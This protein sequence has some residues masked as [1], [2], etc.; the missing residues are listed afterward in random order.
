MSNEI[1]GVIVKR[2]D[3]PDEVTEFGKG[4]FE[5]VT[6]DGMTIGRA[7]Y[8]PGWRWS[9]DVGPGIGEAFCSVEHVGIVVSGDA[10]AAFADGRVAEMKPGDL[11]HLPPEPQDSQV[12]GDEPYACRHL[13]GATRLREIRRIPC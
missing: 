12:V 7:T 6:L 11:F 4:R 5:K 13:L 1:V 9:G 10:T 3:Q 2:F 8:E